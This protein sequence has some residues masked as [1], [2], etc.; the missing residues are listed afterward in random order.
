MTVHLDM[1]DEDWDGLS[2]DEH[3]TE[4]GDLNCSMDGEMEPDL[5]SVLCNHN[6][7]RFDI[8]SFCSCLC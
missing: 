5:V 1:D 4:E 6:Q 7:S 2:N 3:S 8:V